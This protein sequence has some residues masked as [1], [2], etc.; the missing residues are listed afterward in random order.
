MRVTTVRFG[1]D[2]WRLLEAE[3]AR[4]GVS[5]SQ[6]IREA[7][8]ARAA[9]AASIRG[10]DPVALLGGAPEAPVATPLSAERQTAAALRRQAA[11]TR[12]EHRATS[13]EANQAIRRSHQLKAQS[14]KLKQPKRANNRRVNGDPTVRPDS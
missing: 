11:E 3:A 6:Y 7:A 4:S 5:T 9:A 8:L 13:A 12:R 1:V 10:Q 14:A 2:L